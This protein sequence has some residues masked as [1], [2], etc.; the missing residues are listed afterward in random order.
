EMV[1]P[2]GRRSAVVDALRSAHPYEEPAYDVTEVADLPGGRGTGRIGELEE[3]VALSA[4]VARAARALPAT[5]AGLRVAGD[6]DAMVG[7]VAVCGGAGD[8]LL[9]AARSS[10][11]DVYLTA[12]LRH[13]PASESREHGLPALVD[14]AHWATE[15]PWLQEA[16]V[17][18]AERLSARGTTVETR[19]SRIVTDP[20]TA[21]AASDTRSSS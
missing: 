6:P 16:A 3:S 20:W 17:L 2:R 15:W 5:A 1:L 11:A 4:F 19:V 14:A 7:R 10:G 21:Y 12:D 18:L 13:H 8:S 9:D